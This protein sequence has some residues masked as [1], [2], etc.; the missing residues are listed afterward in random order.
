MLKQ[1]LLQIII[2]ITFNSRIQKPSKSPHDRPRN[3]KYVCRES[4]QKWL[5]KKKLLDNKPLLVFITFVLK[6][7]YTATMIYLIKA[8]I[9]TR[10]PTPTAKNN[11]KYNN[12]TS[13]CI[14][15]CTCKDLSQELEREKT[16]FGDVR[17]AKT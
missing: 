1:K 12:C 7:Q 8:F 14:E 4:T 10:T 2:S 16:F 3:K 17:T 6:A 11:S 13:E 15:H 5:Q 9:A